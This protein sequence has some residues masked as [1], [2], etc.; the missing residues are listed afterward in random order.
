M[1]RVDNDSAHRGKASKEADVLIR[2]YVFSYLADARQS[3]VSD[4]RRGAAAEG[5]H[6]G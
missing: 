6:L 5:M 1:R 3:D 4:I 2:F